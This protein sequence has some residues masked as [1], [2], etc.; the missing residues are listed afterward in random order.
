MNDSMLKEMGVDEETLK[1]VQKEVE[2]IQRERRNYYSNINVC[3][4]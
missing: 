2:D 4:N 1:Q 3:L